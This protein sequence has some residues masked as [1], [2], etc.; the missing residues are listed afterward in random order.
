[1][2]TCVLVCVCD[3]ICLS[4]CVCTY[5]VYITQIVSS[6]AFVRRYFHFLIVRACPKKTKMTQCPWRIDF[7]SFARHLHKAEEGVAPIQYRVFYIF[8]LNFK[9][10]KRAHAYG[11][12][13]RCVCV[14]LLFL[15]IIFIQYIHK[16]HSI[17]FRC[18][19]FNL[20]C[21]RFDFS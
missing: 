2:A 5:F 7:D 20:V 21:F 18:G 14:L 15:E 9:L 8:I 3:S 4:V 13:C 6:L 12:L 17:P 16:T 10:F 19:L 11:N 1:M